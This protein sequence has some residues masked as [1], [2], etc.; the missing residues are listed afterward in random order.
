M[1]GSAA[2][3]YGIGQLSWLAEKLGIDEFEVKED[4]TLQ[5]T[6]VLVGKYLTPDF[7][8][9]TSVGVFNRSP[10]LVLKHRLTDELS[11]ETYSGESQRIELKYEFDVE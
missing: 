9:G 10:D 4:E 5:D 1:I 7:Y 11:V 6:L 2:L 8:V 3:S